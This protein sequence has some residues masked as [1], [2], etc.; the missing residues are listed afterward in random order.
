MRNLY[1]T[2]H[3]DSLRYYATVAIACALLY[4]YLVLLVRVTGA[5][6]LARLSGL[7]LVVTIALGSIFGCSILF[8]K[9]P[10]GV[11]ALTAIATM[12]LLAQGA[13]ARW[14]SFARLVGRAP[15]ILARDGRAFEAVL[16]SERVTRDELE[17]AARAAGCASLADV[18]TATLEPNGTITVARRSPARALPDEAADDRVPALR[19]R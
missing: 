14:P 9:L 2:I 12:H 6:T 13:A 19:D 5:R 10:E 7:D 16:L 8:D 17:S 15:A 3:P 18:E 4:A 1:Q 11:V